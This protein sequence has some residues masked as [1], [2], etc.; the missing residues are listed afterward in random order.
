MPTLMEKNI[1]ATLDL[2]KSLK[3]FEAQITIAP[4]LADLTLEHCSR[5]NLQCNGLG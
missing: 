1:D 2:A 3:D 4:F 5:W